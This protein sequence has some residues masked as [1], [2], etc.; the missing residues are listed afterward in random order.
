MRFCDFF[1]DYKLE[2]KS[3]KSTIPWNELPFYRKLAVILIFIL[4]V[5]GLIVIILGYKMPALI[6]LTLCFLLMFIF[7]IIDSTE[8]NQRKMLDEHYSKY[9][10]KRMDAFLKLIKKYNINPLDKESIKLLIE[11]AGEAK[12]KYDVFLPLKKP[13]KTLGAIIIPIIAFVA[14]KLGY[15]TTTDQ[16]IT[17]CIQIVMII[18]CAFAI[19][20]SISP[21]V[22]EII[23]RDSLRYD[24]LIYD[25]KQVLIFYNNKKD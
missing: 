9:S 11:Q 22:K 10:K 5:I 3:I 4:G 16:L 15:A 21:I 1:I 19:L 20:F 2:L 13:I 6:L 23:N 8:K 24:D 7:I 18:I 14:Q 17:M 25:L 12:I